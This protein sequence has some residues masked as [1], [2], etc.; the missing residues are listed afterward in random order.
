MQTIKD[1]SNIGKL[2]SAPETKINCDSII[3][4]QRQV[5]ERTPVF[6]DSSICLISEI[7]IQESAEERKVSLVK[8]VRKKLTLYSNRNFEANSCHPSINDP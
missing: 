1:H 5:V 4:R 3:N 6:D 2:C 8:H 7:I